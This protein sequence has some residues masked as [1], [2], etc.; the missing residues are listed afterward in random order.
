MIQIRVE[1]SNHGFKH[2]VNQLSAK[3]LNIANTR[4]I[5]KGLAK[6][7]TEYKLVLT[8]QYNITSYDAGKM[9][10]SVKA[11]YQAPVGKLKA[12]VKP[13]NFGRFNPTFVKGGQILSV[14][15]LK[16]EKGKKRAL[17]QRSKKTNKQEG[18]GVSLQIKKG[19]TK[20]L[21]SAFMLTKQGKYGGMDTVVWGRG[22]YTGVGS[23][24][25]GNFKPKESKW[26]TKI[27][28]LKSLS[29]FSVIRESTYQTKIQTSTLEASG[30]ELQR[31]VLLL[32]RK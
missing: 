3:K 7:N 11:S 13:I 20:T 6:G 21:P 2:L 15:A 5:N 29:A 22:T 9:L 17:V 28:P 26:K 18:R 23:F 8:S 24:L 32:L 14:K 31:Q 1:D 10:S 4:A 19:V 30:K 25:W 12:N 16:A 27:T